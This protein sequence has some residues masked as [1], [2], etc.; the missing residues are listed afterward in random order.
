MRRKRVPF[1]PTKTSQDY[2][3]AYAS[4]T[5]DVNISSIFYDGEPLN[6]T[7][8]VGGSRKGCV[9]VTVD[10]K[11]HSDDRMNGM[12][13]P[14]I[15][16]VPVLKRWPECATNKEV[17]SGDGSRAMI[18]AALMVARDVFPYIERFVFTDASYVTC[19]NGK[20]LS[21]PHY[22]LAVHGKTWY[23]TF[24]HAELQD[25]EIKAKYKKAKRALHR[26]SSKAPFAIA[27]KNF[28]VRDAK[29][30]DDLKD[31]YDRAET[32]TAF[33]TALKKA[34]SQD[35][36]CETVQSWIEG[37]IDDV[38]E[39]N[40]FAEYWFIAAKRIKKDDWKVTVLQNPPVYRIQG[41]GKSDGRRGSNRT[42]ACVLGDFRDFV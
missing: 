10:A 26:V 18:R 42:N 15:A 33:F 6:H 13:K 29:M 30:F 23:E 1:D 34:F 20:D 12:L 40:Y 11:S 21:L 27:F 7:I 4:Y 14:K 35:E 28:Y 38:L 16:K 19:A 31:I 39:K 32:Y 9:T 5:F 3:V 24:F 17:I 41:G 36:F 22:Y 25:P 2:T 37:F 8:S